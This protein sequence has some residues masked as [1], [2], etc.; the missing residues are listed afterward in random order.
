MIRNPTLI[1][2]LP[3]T[4]DAY[5]LSATI[6]RSICSSLRLAGVL[7]TYS[8]ISVKRVSTYTTKTSMTEQLVEAI[9]VA[10]DAVTRQADTVRSLKA[11]VK[12]GKIAKV[13]DEVEGSM[14]IAISKHLR[15]EQ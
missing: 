11:D 2:C 6:L 14:Q 3:L 12:G 9:Q 15:A 8:S 13:R 7:K 10:Q 1:L 5:P 4:C